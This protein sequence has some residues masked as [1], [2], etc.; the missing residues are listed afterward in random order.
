VPDDVGY[1][2]IKEFSLLQPEWSPI[3]DL[4][5]RDSTR[6]KANLMNRK[7]KNDH[8]RYELPDG[9]TRYELV[10]DTRKRTMTWNTPIAETWVRDDRTLDELQVDDTG[11]YWPQKSLKARFPIIRVKHEREYVYT[12]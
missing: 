5:F 1:C 10:E 4:C 7:D 2:P 3:Y 11:G 6:T 9:Q 8:R 12:N